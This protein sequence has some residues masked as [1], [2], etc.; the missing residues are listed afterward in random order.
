MVSLDPEAC[1]DV[2][3]VDEDDDFDDDEADDD[4]DDL[5]SFLLE[6]Q[7]A[8]PKANVAAAIATPMAGADFFIRWSPRVFSAGRRQHRSPD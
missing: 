3:V 4:V 1:A 8:S 6:S 2:D 7:P 5:V